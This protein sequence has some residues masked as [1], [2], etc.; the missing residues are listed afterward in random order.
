MVFDE[1]I[2]LRKNHDYANEF[3]YLLKE[4]SSEWEEKTDTVVNMP[5]S[6][7]C[8]INVDLLPIKSHYFFFYGAMG[9]VMPFM[10][11]LAKGLGINATA[12]GLVYTVLPF[13]VFLSNPLFGFIT[14]YFQNIKV[15]IF[16]LVS[17]T[18]VSYWSVILLPSIDNTHW[19]HVKIH[20]QVQ[21]NSFSILT[22]DYNQT[23]IN[24]TLM[25]SENGELS[26]ESCESNSTINLYG[27]VSIEH[28]RNVRTNESF[29]SPNT[30]WLEF[31]PET[32]FSCNC[33]R[34]YSS[35][36]ACVNI[37][38]CLLVED[39]V[40]VYKTYQ[41]W[42]FTLLAVISGTGATT[43]FCLS[44]A[45]CYEV[46]AERT[47][48]YGKQRLWATMSW[49]LTTLLAGFS[50]DIATGSFESINYAPG[51][52]LM[53]VLVGVDLILL[54]KIRLVKAKLSRNIYSDVGKILS[55][56]ETVCFATAVYVMGAM[57]GLLWGYQFWLLQDLGATQT[58]LGLCTAVQCLIAEVPFFFFSGWFI[59]TFGYFYCV[60]GAL[61]AFGLRYGL[62][63]ILE[64]PWLVLPIEV[65]Q[66]LTFAVF[67]TAMTGYA[68]NNAPPGTA[69]TLM[70][71]LG[72]LFEG[73][74]V[75]TG[76]LLGGFGFDKIG[77]RKTFLIAACISLVC[78]PLL[79]IVNIVRRKPYRK[80]ETSNPDL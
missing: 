51:F 33:I 71:I 57:S 63:Y 65:L 9:A 74:G 15:I 18:A 78:A 53:L 38:P 61:A 10:P 29:D 34:E 7:R 31:K 23:C 26:F 52:Y 44:D 19:T 76:S 14:D 66:G 24:H 2:A 46:L 68:S 67:Y 79:A 56:Y 28:R 17:A 37:N 49:G 3:C 20:C 8:H 5:W 12:V 72:G 69:T 11:V 73:L 1:N 60:S 36:L 80:A 75:A 13:C 25:D 47:D 70:G 35:V 64:N 39:S 43:V 4:N 41:F 77:G 58:L 50:N 27:N 59:K 30:V 42:V 40:S 54:F 55:S 6:K 32:N 48:L 62:Y 16:I 22:N 21:N 45:A